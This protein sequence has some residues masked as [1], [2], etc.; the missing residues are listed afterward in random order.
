MPSGFL[1]APLYPVLVYKLASTVGTG[2]VLI[3]LYLKD[4]SSSLYSS[5]KSDIIIGMVNTMDPE[6]VPC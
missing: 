3:A 2:R 1:L 5:Q 4:P 6:V